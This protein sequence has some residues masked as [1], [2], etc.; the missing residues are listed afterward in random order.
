MELIS[1][2]P[3]ILKVL[4]VALLGLVALLWKWEKSKRK[5]AEQERDN[6]KASYELAGDVAGIRTEGE[7]AVE[8]IA[9]MD[10]DGIADAFH[11]G[12]CK[13]GSED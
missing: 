7:K 10:V 11:S 2:L 8:E 13:P 12:V 3:V 1:L 4:P 5:A 6:F 9:E